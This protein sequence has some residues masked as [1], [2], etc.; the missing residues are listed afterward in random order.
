MSFSDL[1]ISRIYYLTGNTVSALLGFGGGPRISSDQIGSGI[2]R[3]HPPDRQGQ[4]PAAKR[5]SLERPGTSPNSGKIGRKSD[6]AAQE[7]AAVESA[8][9]GESQAEAE[10]DVEDNLDREGDG[11]GVGD[12]NRDDVAGS[13]EQGGIEGEEDEEGDSDDYQGDAVANQQEE[14][15]GEAEDNPQVPAL[16]PI[17]AP[18]QAVAPVAPLPPP[19]PPPP[20]VTPAPRQ[21][22]PR[23]TEAQRL[24]EENRSHLRPSRTR[25]NGR[26][27][28]GR[29]RGM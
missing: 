24:V 5:T 11:D 17:P 4:S 26:H 16:N 23:R 6:K 28:A 14:N 21:P 27:Q 20:P 18:A 1:Y 29:Y 3:S 12:D 22:P 13:N 15:E 8:L 2:K 19:P 9:V 25:N 7:L 10:E